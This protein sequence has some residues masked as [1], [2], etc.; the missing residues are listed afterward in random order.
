MR[1]DV[2][3]M[4]RFGRSWVRSGGG[5]GGF[6]VAARKDYLKCVFSIACTVLILR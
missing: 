1:G 5:F 6:E 4:I 2:D 3:V